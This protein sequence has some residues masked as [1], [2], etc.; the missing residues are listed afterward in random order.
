MM[1]AAHMTAPATGRHIDVAVTRPE[2]AMAA[3]T[4][5]TIAV[6]GLGELSVATD[7]VECCAEECPAPPEAPTC[8][9]L[10]QRGFVTYVR[11]H[12][13]SD[14]TAVKG[15]YRRQRPRTATARTTARRSVPHGAP[16][17]RTRP[18]Q[19]GPTTYVA[20]YYRADGSRVRGHRRSIS[21]RDVAAV[22]G[23]GGGLTVL[24]LVLLAV[25]GG[26]G[27]ISETP[28]RTTPSPSASAQPVHR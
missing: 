23:A 20:P 9:R 19:T 6:V 21:P 7:T 15:H 4:P 13:R 10:H 14:G 26:P 2:I 28:V 25:A 11:P 8:P 22:G 18:V 27:D 16:V 24:I 5:P 1:S 12:V 17:L 3:P